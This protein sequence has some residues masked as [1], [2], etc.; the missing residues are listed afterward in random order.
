MLNT[1]L[2]PPNLMI[3]SD[4][5]KAV[6]ELVK[7]GSRQDM[8]WWAYKISKDKYPNFSTNYLMERARKA[9]KRNVY[10]TELEPAYE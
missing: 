1:T 2:N 3:S 9:V 6:A 10:T 7:M 4:K 5:V 8:E